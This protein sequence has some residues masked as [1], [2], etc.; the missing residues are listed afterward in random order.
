VSTTLL[1]VFLT[2]RHIQTYEAFR[3]EYER[4]AAQI[5]PELR[6][7]APSRAQYYRW[8]TGQ[9]RGGT[10]YPDACRVLEGMFPPWRAADLLGPPS[11]QLSADS[12]PNGGGCPAELLVGYWLTTYRFSVGGA[13]RHVDIAHIEA[14]TDRL[15]TAVNS[16]PE[17]QTEGHSQPFRNTIEAQLVG[18]H[19]IG[20]W[21]N[22][23]DTRYHGALH[24]A[25]AP[26]EAQMDG[27]YTGLDSDTEV[28]AAR[29]RWVRIDPASLAAVDLAAV[30][31]REPG[32]IAALLDDHT[33][34]DPP[35]PITAVVEDR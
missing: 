14:V 9:L 24:L 4:A 34:Y 31:L 17:P 2:Q 33:Q 25:V 16:T 18:R 28:S 20:R 1:K 23:S 19:L 8:L 26:G 12:A 7:T 32:A 29:W 30:R 6:G 27:W 10:P 15:V 13:K 5:A 21:R 35:L 3:A 11:P 22:T